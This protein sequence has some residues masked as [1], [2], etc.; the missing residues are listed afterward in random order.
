MRAAAQ[1]LA[2]QRPARI[3]VAVPVAARETCEALSRE[4][5]EI[6]CALMPEPFQAVGLWYDDFDQTSDDDVRALLTQNRR[7]AGTLDDRPI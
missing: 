7:D 6:V 3:V 4:V 5:D 1:A 2:G